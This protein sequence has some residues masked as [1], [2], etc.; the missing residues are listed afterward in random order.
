VN[1]LSSRVD[2][3]SPDY[4]TNKEGNLQSL[5]TLHKHLAKA[6]A[7]GGEKY[8]TRHKA[9]GKLLPRERL[10][11]L[12]DRDSPFLELLPLAGL[13]VGGTI[14]GG[15]V[16][17]G[18][19]YVNGTECVLSASESTIQGGAIGPIGVKKA[20]RI[21]QVASENALPAIHIIESAGA[22]LP[23]QSE[24]F[25]PGGAGFRDIT[26]RSAAQ[27]PTI[28]LVMGSCTAGGAYIPG[29]S[30]YTV[31]V[32]EA[33]YMYLAGPPL[34][35]MATGEV[36]DDESL[37]GAAM[38]SKISG[39][40][41]YLASDE[42]DCIRL[43]RE[44]VGLL[45][46]KKSGPAATGPADPPK[47]DAEELLGIASADIK[48]PFDAREVLA[49]IVDGS[50]FHE[51][52][53]LYGPTLVTGWVEIA[54][55]R[56]GVL[57]NNGILFSDSAEKGAQFIQLCNQTHTPL[58]FMQNITGFMVGQAAEERGIIKAGAKL[59]NAVSNSTVPAI[60]LMM[61]GSYGA[62][63]YAMMGRAYDPRFVFA[64]PNHKLAVMGSEQLAGV[65]EI[66]KRGAAAKRGKE[67]NEQELAM[68]KQMLAGK[69]E[70]ESSCWQVTGRMFD[71]GII[72]PRD[73]R[74]VLAMA[75][76]AIHS[77]PVRGTNVWGTVRH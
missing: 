23:N 43:G 67:V 42:Q 75:L 62:G 29:M 60:T 44:L 5:E 46:W 2:L 54:G 53:P 34:V 40:S 47:Y 6:R 14:P 24:I 70:H 39:V 22:D 64:W 30:D 76:S 59:I 19:G 49:R 56:V 61:G 15:S 17:A 25:V 57:A 28:S 31:M 8:V 35:K 27:I 65:I 41:D 18:I 11:L 10:D 13:H 16:V 21:A 68:M 51:F 74:S 73:T 52:K 36:I 33:A 37:G 72:D 3:K 20:A 77:A 1:V 71:D 38:H 55:Y 26:R 7:G 32:N 12:L 48:V 69:V 9:R 4:Q 58:L 63:N 45:G 50:R 66:V